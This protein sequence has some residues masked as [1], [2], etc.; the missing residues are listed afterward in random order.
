MTAKISEFNLAQLAS[1]DG[2]FD[3]QFRKD[4]RHDRTGSPTYYRWKA[5]FII[6]LPKEQVD[7]LEKAKKTI[8][9]GTVSKTA[10][11]ARFSVQNIDDIADGVIPYFT[12]HKLSGNKK[13]DF[14]LWQKAVQIIYQNKRTPLSKWKKND[15]LSLLQI[16]KASA[17]YKIKP[18]KSKWMEMAQVLV[19]KP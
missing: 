4:T 5:Q 8:G 6:T 11:Q 18:K 17:K 13:Q 14:S 12:Q 7:I 19:K 15:L 16:H 2:C 9:C 3:L 1:D 10:T